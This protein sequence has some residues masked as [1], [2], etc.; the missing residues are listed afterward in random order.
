MEEIIRIIDNKVDARELWEKL[1]V[2]DKFA[3]WISR[4]I[5]KYGFQE[6]LDFAVRKNATGE[7]NGFQAIDYD[8][9]IDTAKE[10]AMVENNEA[11]RKIRQYFIWVE[12]KHRAITS[13]LSPQLQVLINLELK[14]KQLEDRTETVERTLTLIKGAVI[15]EEPD[16]RKS[17]NAKFNRIVEAVGDRKFKEIRTESYRLLDERAHV[18]IDMRLEKLR[19]RLQESG[20]SKTKINNANKM[21]IIED[22][23]KLREIYG[24][25]IQE[26]FIKYVA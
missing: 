13:D 25:I 9:T 15:D 12:N 19:G 24:K 10:L 1:G 21:D 20:A 26:L 5:E 18:N 6:S 4:R 14:Q 17:I 3:T 23:P 16:W 7:S 22:D 11:G 8:L 2:Q